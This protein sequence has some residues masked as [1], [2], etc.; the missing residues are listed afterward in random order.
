MV[1]PAK[2]NVAAPLAPRGANTRST[3]NRI[4]RQR[5]LYLFILPALVLIFL[6]DYLPMYGVIIAFKNFNPLLGIWGSRWAGLTNFNRL[7]GNI[8]FWR[9]FRNT[10][11][12]NLLHI[13]IGFPAPIVLALLLNEIR[14]DPVKRGVQTITYLPHFLSWVI[15]GG[16][17]A[18]V[19]SP[20]GG[21]ITMVSQWLTGEKS[22]TFLMI[23]PAWFRWILVFSN[24]WKSMGWD[25]IIYIA[26]ISGINP[27]LYEAAVIDGASRLRKMMSI[28]LPSISQAITILFL[29]RIGQAMK[30]NFDQIFVLYSPSVYSTGDVI[31]TYVYREGLGAGEFSYSTAVGL[32]ES[33]V[34]FALLITANTVVRRI[35]GS[36]LW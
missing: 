23:D 4:K 6:F 31:S 32:F 21:I 16:F 3:W 35:R 18:Q 10:L 15:A 13:L 1:T 14:I 36:G 34:G 17:V 30:S 12:I 9:I 27:E 2:K 26:A 22:D 5:V 20:N 29:L 8:F 11:I 25:S 19:L 7:V 28:T 24:V 33:L